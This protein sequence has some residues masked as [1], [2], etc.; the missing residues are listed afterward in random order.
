MK[1]RNTLPVCV[2]LTCFTLDAA[3]AQGT[4]KGKANAVEG[5]DSP[6]I[7]IEFHPQ[8]SAHARS[9]D[10]IGNVQLLQMWADYGN[11]MVLVKPGQLLARD[12]W[13]DATLSSKGHMIDTRN[14]TDPIYQLPGERLGNTRKPDHASMTDEP[15]IHE[16][17]LPPFDASSNPTGWKRMV[18]RFHTFGYC[19]AGNERGKWY[20]GVEWTWEIPAAR[21]NQTDGKGKIKILNHNVPPP[22]AVSPFREALDKY[23]KAK[24][25]KAP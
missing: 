24:S 12:A 18:W 9:C 1:I 19:N 7:T 14:S 6:S 5:N 11:R 20:E 16:S 15:A 4:G 22:E 23:M 25:R 3:H 8:R 10:E 13:L 17:N 21:A 2:M